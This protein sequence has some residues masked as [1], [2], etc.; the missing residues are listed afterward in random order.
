MGSIDVGLLG[1]NEYK[2]YL[3]TRMSL[4]SNED[5]VYL[6]LNTFYTTLLSELILN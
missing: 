5:V 6:L 3:A 1:E 2:F 4:V